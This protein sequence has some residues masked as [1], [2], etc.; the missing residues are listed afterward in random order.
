LE[1]EERGDE[2]Y[3]DDSKS[4]GYFSPQKKNRAAQNADQ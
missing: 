3:E 4:I 1:A 2:V